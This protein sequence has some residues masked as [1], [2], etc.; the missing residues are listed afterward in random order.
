MEILYI[1]HCMPW[2][3]DKGDRIRAFHS[4]R[5]L[6]EHHQVHVACLARTRQE[7]AAVS[8]LAAKCASV[9]IE[10][11]DKPRSMLRGF[12][13]FALGRS[14]TTSFY[15]HPRL[16]AYISSVIATRPIG[17]VVL[18]STG[19]AAYE[20]AGIPFI[21]DWGDVD[22][23]K[24]FDYARMRFPRFA[25]RMEAARLRRIERDCAARSERTFFTTP[26]ELQ[27]FQRIAPEAPAACAGNGVDTDFFN[28]AAS[29]TTPAS[30]H[31]RKYL[32]F[33]G[34]LNYF[35]NSDGVCWFAESIY[36][37]LR[38]R[39][40][41]LELLLVGRNPPRTVQ[42]LDKHPGVTVVGAVDDARP[43]LAAAR[44]VVVP[45]RIAR[46]IQNKVLEALAMGKPVLASEE[47][48]RTLMPELPQGITQCRSADDYACAAAGLPEA[49][50]ASAHIAGAAA[51]RFSW[52]ANLAPMLAE[53]DRIE[54]ARRRNA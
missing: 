18:L 50:T 52:A 47:V 25:Y 11:L 20:P 12:A 54:A 31:R 44:G 30:L 53:L 1:S 42:E 26:N 51:A 46:G 33:V 5:Q 45:L 29:F 6:V 27:L 38:R 14:L 28:P 10:V 41:D 13:G 24:W 49:C 17:A 3:P 4:V 40:P 21:A 35:P 7:A 37:E 36:P 16:Q 43:Y 48:C 2:P 32:V 9:R 34:M 19:M 39:D 8:D 23:E 15:T 22:S